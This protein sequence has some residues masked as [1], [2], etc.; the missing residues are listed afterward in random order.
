MATNGF[1]STWSRSALLAAGIEPTPYALK[2]LTLWQKSTPLEAWTK[3]PIGLPAKGYSKRKIPGTDYALFLRTPDFNNAFVKALDGER[4]GQIR[5]LLGEGSSTAKLWRAI[6]SLQWPANTTENEWPREI[7]T[8]IGDEYRAKL[9]MKDPGPHKS[10]GS[11]GTINASQQMV[12]NHTHA[13]VTAVQAKLDFARAVQ[14]IVKG[15]K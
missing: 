1:A 3:N 5:I 7:Y 10:S 15:V 11:P 9:G 12:I 6:N 8:W 2:A 4:D 13:M 14:F